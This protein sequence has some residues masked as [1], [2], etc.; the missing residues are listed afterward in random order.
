MPFTLAHPI[1]IL[2]LW[3]LSKHRLDLSALAIGATIPDISYF[4]ALQPVP[5]IGHSLIGIVIEGVPSGVV[6]LLI[7]RYWLWKPVRSLLP[8]A[9][10]TRVPTQTP[11]SVLSIPRLLNIVLSIAIGAL[12]HIIWD[13]FTHSYGWGVQRFTWLS[14]EIAG[15]SIYKGLQYGCGVFGFIILL[16]LLAQFIAKQPQKYQ[17]SKLP[18]KQQSIAWAGIST[19]AILMISV[20]VLSNANDSLSAV[21]VSMVIGSVSGLGLGLCLYA[22][23]FWI[24]KYLGDKA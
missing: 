15:L 21:V 3:Q 5:N 22:T 6:L 24:A 13:S 4:V 17:P 20:A 12:T 2:P 18:S 7:G 19:V 1:A 8:S 9:L 23:A 16:V 14:A 11:Y 10:A